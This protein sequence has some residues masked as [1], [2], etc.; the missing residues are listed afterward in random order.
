MGEKEAEMAKTEGRLIANNKKAYHDYFILEKYEAGIVLHGTEVKSLR[1]GK[2]S[3]KEAFVRVDGSEMYIYGMHISPYEK[4][5]IFNKDPLRK[6]K[7]L[8]HKRE[9]LKISGKMKEQGITVVPLQVY[10]R[11]SLVKVEIGLVRGKKIYDKRN[12]I[13]KKDQKR[14]IQREFKIKNL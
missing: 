6:R 11:G 10:F 8:L 5:N 12:D 7:L 2:C 13:A 1:M 9:I 4:G 14:E 3:I